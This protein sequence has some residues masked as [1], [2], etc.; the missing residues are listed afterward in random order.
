MACHSLLAK[1]QQIPLI[2]VL[3]P[4]SIHLFVI[5]SYTHQKKRS[6]SHQILHT[7]TDAYV[8]GLTVLHLWVNL[9]MDL[10]VGP[11]QIWGPKK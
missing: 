8:R 10:G 1:L 7:I 2:Q 3:L 4:T 9:G 11:E 6:Y 5:A